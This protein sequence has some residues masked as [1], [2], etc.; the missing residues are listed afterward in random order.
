[1]PR[2]AWSKNLWQYQS[3]R[4]LKLELDAGGRSTCLCS[5]QILSSVE[6]A[7]TG[8]CSTEYVPNA[9]FTGGSRS[10]TLRKWNRSLQFRSHRIGWAAELAPLL[11]RWSFTDN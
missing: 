7:E 8:C 5:F 6:T 1:M 10:L 4:H 3:I 11:C 2:I 9:D